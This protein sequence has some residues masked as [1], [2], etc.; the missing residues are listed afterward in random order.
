MTLAAL[1]NPA[2]LARMV[3]MALL[4][5]IAIYAEAAPLGLGPSAPPSPDLLLCVVVYWTVRRPEATPLLAI[6]ALGLMR[7]FI[8]DAPLGAGALSLVIVTEILKAQRRRVQRS[9]F[10]LEWIALGLAVLGATA[11]QWLLV[12]LTFMQPPYLMDLL[13]QCLYTV[14]VY[15]ALALLFRWVL[16]ITWPAPEPAF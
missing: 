10:Y 5:L 1:T 14:M 15:P 12:V 11:F 7:D 9:G 2:R 8:T 16:R 6:F 3:L 4:C 13:H